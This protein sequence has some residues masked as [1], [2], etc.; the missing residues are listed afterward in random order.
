MAAFFDDERWYEVKEVAEL[1]GRTPKAV[2]GLVK[3]GN[4]TGKLPARRVAGR[5]FVSEKDLLSFVFISSGRY[6]KMTAYRVLLD[7][8]KDYDV[9]VV[10]T[11]KGQG[12]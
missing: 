11:C 6:G 3:H 2:Y 10:P 8:S 5:V 9:G 1:T 4:Q 7:G 12:E